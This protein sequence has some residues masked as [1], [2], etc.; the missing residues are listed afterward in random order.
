MAADET[1]AA[2]NGDDAIG[3]FEKFGHRLGLRFERALR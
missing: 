3:G 2:E 1:G